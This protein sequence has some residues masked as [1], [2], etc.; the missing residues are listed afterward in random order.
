MRKTTQYIAIHCSATPAAMDIG[1]AEIRRW[2]REKGWRDIGYQ[3][4]IRRDGTIEMGRGMDSIGAH[5][6]GYNHASVGICLVGGLSVTGEPEN[7][8]T[9]AQMQSLRILVD[10]LRQR[11]PGVVVQGHR[12]FPNVSKACP[13]FDVPGWYQNQQVTE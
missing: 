7:N 11:Y 1:V 5:V 6:R 2:H 8:F 9:P 12:D 4:V 3:A 13:C 10:G